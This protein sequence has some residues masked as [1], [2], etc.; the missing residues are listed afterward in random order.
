MCFMDETFSVAVCAYKSQFAIVRAAGT[1][2]HV[3]LS[4]TAAREGYM[5]SKLLQLQ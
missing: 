3:R 5:I 4:L 2:C 1:L